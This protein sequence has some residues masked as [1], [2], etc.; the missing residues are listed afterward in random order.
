MYQSKFDKLYKQIIQQ[1]YQPVL[2][3][4][5]K[6]TVFGRYGK[7]LL[8]VFPKL[9]NI[10]S[11]W[12]QFLMKYTQPSE[13]RQLNTFQ[14]TDQAYMQLIGRIPQKKDVFLL[15]IYHLKGRAIKVYNIR[16]NQEMDIAGLNVIAN[17]KQF[18]NDIKKNLLV[19]AGE[20]PNQQDRV[21][22]HKY[23]LVLNSKFE[24]YNMTWTDQLI[25]KYLPQFDTYNEV[26]KNFIKKYTCPYHNAAGTIVTNTFLFTVQGAKLFRTKTSTKWVIKYTKAQYGAE[27][28]KIQK[29]SDFLLA[30]AFQNEIP[31]R[32]Q[33]FNSY[34]CTRSKGQPKNMNDIKVQE[35]FYIQ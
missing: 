18:G 26:F 15:N 9:K 34:I 4:L 32:Q 12:D 3:G 2:K 10:A 31:Y 6:L 28:H 25:Q 1:A 23:L 11:Y 8:Q 22:I 24:N 5:R 27:F 13:S 14:L 17:T 30:I 21:D 29:Q 7:S 16:D 19:F 35:A 33:K 20:I